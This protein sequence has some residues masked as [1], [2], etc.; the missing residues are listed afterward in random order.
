MKTEKD[1]KRTYAN[2]RWVI[3][4]V[5]SRIAWVTGVYIFTDRGFALHSGCSFPLVN[6][7]PTYSAPR[8]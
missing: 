7:R 6:K 8:C 4:G 5:Y 1:K 3:S 2:F